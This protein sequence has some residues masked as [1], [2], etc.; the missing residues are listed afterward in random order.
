MS[1]ADNYDNRNFGSTISSRVCDSDI[2]SS[3]NFNY[4]ANCDEKTEEA[5]GANSFIWNFEDYFTI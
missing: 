3:N 4:D 5:C 2:Y 1:E